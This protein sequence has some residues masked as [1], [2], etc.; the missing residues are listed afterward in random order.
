MVGPRPLT[1]AVV[2][3]QVKRIF[4]RPLLT[5]EEMP[6]SPIR[7]ILET[8]PGRP[9]DD[10]GIVWILSPT[11]WWQFFSKWRRLEELKVSILAAVWELP[12]QLFLIPEEPLRTSAAQ[13][14]LH[15]GTE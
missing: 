11:P 6:L 14:E 9:V 10:S 4:V 2:A 7:A 5:E 3:A 13:T 8:G 12:L 15:F 1:G